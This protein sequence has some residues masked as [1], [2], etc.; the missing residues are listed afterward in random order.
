MQWAQR[1]PLRPDL[2]DDPVQVMGLL[3]EPVGLAAGWTERAFV[4]PLA[5]LGFGC[6]EAAP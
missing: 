6:I 5:A 3:S 1:A 2:P 4:E